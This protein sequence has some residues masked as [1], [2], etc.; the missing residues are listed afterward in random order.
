MTR[1]IKY[2][3]MTIA[4]LI[5]FLIFPFTVAAAHMW[6]ETPIIKG[7]HENRTILFSDQIKTNMDKNIDLWAETP[8]RS[9]ESSDGN[10]MS[11]LNQPQRKNNLFNKMY[12][13]TPDLN[14][15]LE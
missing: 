15:N 5:L 9:E 14:L 12:D 10:L 2:K 3:I 8:S 6:D 11:N 4:T 7:D 1:I 13:E